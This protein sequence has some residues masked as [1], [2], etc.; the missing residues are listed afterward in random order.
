MNSKHKLWVEK[1]RPQKIE[2]YI[3]QDEDLKKKIVRMIE[4]KS[5]PH[6]LFSGVQG[7]GK[8]TL[9]FILIRE[10]GL[11]PS[12]VLTLN[13]SDETGVD[14]MR[15]KIKSFVSSHSF[16][17][18]KIVHL[19]EADY[20]SKSA[21]AIL[22]RLMEDY[23]DHARFMMTCNYEK[24]IIPAIHS[25]CHHFHFNKPD[26]DEVLEYIYKILI[27]EDIKTDFETL[28]KFVNAGFPDIRKIINMVQQNSVDGKLHAG[29][30]DSNSDYHLDLMELIGNDKWAEARQ[31]ACDQ[32]D[33]EEW[34][35]LYQ[36]LYENLAKYGKF[37]D[38]R[39]WEDA[40]V[41][42]A[43]HLYK[44]GQVAY[45][46]INGAALFIRLAQI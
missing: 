41:V 15:D 19:E 16:G 31:L 21:Q 39:K 23:S 10:M 45:P 40:I 43:E 17:D 25:R 26:F 34:E 8:T 12:D 28:E 27:E 37:K 7:S 20:L 32:V 33:D 13:A 44:H 36:T 24:K 42:I 3:F 38:Q 11:D 29:E 4:E 14:N 1:Y 30:A 35:D 5:I 18:F 22:R 9:A 46:E 6:L 2:D